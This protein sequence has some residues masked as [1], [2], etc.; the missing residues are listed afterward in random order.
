MEPSENTRNK[1][2]NLSRSD[3]ASNSPF[4]VAVF[5]SPAKLS[6]SNEQSDSACLD[7]AREYTPEEVLEWETQILTTQEYEK[8]L[9]QQVLDEGE[10]HKSKSTLD[11]T[12]NPSCKNFV[13]ISRFYNV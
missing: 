1:V 9:E 13:C 11:S 4:E 5:A 7:E 8:Y 2:A 6:N 3:Q 10:E 12:E